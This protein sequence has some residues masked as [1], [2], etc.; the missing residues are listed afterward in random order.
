M[1][2]ETVA[3][4]GFG[5]SGPAGGFVMGDGAA[6]LG[7]VSGI[8]AGGAGGMAGGTAYCMG[9]GTGGV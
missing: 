8:G 2:L 3:A 6:C 5:I 9:R 1:G 7:G 4:A